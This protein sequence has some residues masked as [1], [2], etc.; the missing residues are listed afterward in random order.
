VK[1]LAGFVRVSLAPGEETAVRFRLH[2][3]QAAFTGPDLRRIVEPGDMDVMVGR[4]SADLPCRA[5]ARLTGPRRVVDRPRRFLTEVAV[6]VAGAF[7]DDQE[8]R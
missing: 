6:D 8:S 5:R 1:Q 7:A 3:D 4:S 2:A